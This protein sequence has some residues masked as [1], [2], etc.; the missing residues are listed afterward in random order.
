MKE[1]LYLLQFASGGTLSQSE[2][3]VSEQEARDALR[4][5]QDNNECENIEFRVIPVGDAPPI[6]IDADVES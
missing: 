5:W 4:Y 1:N 6:V 3:P 2:G